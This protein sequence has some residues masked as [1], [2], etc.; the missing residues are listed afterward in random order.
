MYLCKICLKQ[1]ESESHFCIPV[2][3]GFLISGLMGLEPQKYGAKHTYFNQYD[4]LNLSGV[5][6][7]GRKGLCWAI[8]FRW[9]KSAH[10][11][12][13]I[14]NVYADSNG[15][16]LA[17][18]VKPGN[19]A[20]GEVQSVTKGSMMGLQ[21]MRRQMDQ[22]QKGYRDASK[23]A[24]SGARRNLLVKHGRANK[25]AGGFGSLNASPT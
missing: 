16:R 8:S 20:G 9:I 11:H 10:K 25:E 4:F 19:G 13:F 7:E 23:H 3:T 14:S 1:V 18:V 17:K 21:S 22:L 5:S 6:E 12:G 2:K 15:K 24:D